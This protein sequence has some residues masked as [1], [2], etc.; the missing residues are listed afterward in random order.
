MLPRSIPHR[1]VL[2]R[3]LAMTPPRRATDDFVRAMARI[4]VLGLGADGVLRVGRWFGAINLRKGT[5]VPLTALAWDDLRLRRVPSSVIYMRRW[6][7]SQEPSFVAPPGDVLAALTS[8]ASSVADRAQHD[9]A[10]LR[11]IG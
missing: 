1:V 9:L 10:L 11:R 7:S 3:Y 8:I 5:D 4:A 2:G 6:E